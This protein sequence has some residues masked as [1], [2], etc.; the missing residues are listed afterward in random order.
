LARKPFELDETHVE[1]G[2]ALARQKGKA[3]LAHEVALELAG[4]MVVR[5]AASAGVSEEIWNRAMGKCYS[6]LV[7]GGY[8]VIPGVS[9]DGPA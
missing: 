2:R 1:R 4:A 7:G 6:L 8:I 3:A 9:T 5:Q